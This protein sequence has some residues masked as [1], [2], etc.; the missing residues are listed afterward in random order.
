M[1]YELNVGWILLSALLLAFTSR[2]IKAASAL[3]F[4]SSM[5]EVKK[6]ILDFKDWDDSQKGRAIDWLKGDKLETFIGLPNVD[7][8]AALDAELNASECI[9]ILVVVMVNHTILHC[10][11]SST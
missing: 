3:V 1:H 2:A 8:Q 10:F 6:Q 4:K 5:E 9:C 11:I 7:L